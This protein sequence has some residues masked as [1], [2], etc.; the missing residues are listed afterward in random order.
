MRKKYKW[1][2]GITLLL[3]SAHVLESINNN[4]I[5]GGILCLVQNRRGYGIVLVL[6]DV[7]WF[8]VCMFAAN[9]NHHCGQC[10]IRR[11]WCHQLIV[12]HLLCLDANN[13]ILVITI[14]EYCDWNEV[15][16]KQYILKHVYGPIASIGSRI[17][18]KCSNRTEIYVD[19]RSEVKSMTEISWPRYAALISN[20]IQR[21]D[22]KIVELLGTQK[23]VRR[24]SSQ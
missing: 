2:N 24:R 20:C 16:K 4:K 15:Y 7:C 17:R 9:T 19:R 6:H 21:N 5:I 10:F 1:N 13:I 8:L 11:W 3:C 23:C 12:V 18:N 22:N 14:I